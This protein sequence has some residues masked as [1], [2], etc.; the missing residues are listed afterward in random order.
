MDQLTEM[1]YRN[2]CFPY[3]SYIRI[4]L[5]QLWDLFIYLFPSALRC[6]RAMMAL[7]FDEVWDD[8]ECNQMC[9]VCRHGNGEENLFVVQSASV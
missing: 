8:E 5:V 7:H 2:S 1:D 3:H 6:R 9:D 4:K